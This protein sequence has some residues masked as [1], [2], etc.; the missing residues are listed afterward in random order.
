MRN[1]DV[2]LARLSSAERAMWDTISWV[3]KLPDEE[4][5]PMERADSFSFT[6]QSPAPASPERDSAGA[7]APLFAT[8]D[9]GSVQAA[10]L[11]CELKEMPAVLNFAHGF[12]CG[13]GFDHAPGSQEEDIFRKTSLFLSLWPH[14]R[15]DDGPGVLKRGKW[16]G[17]FDRYLP[18]KDAFYPHTECGG[19]YSP[20]VRVIRDQSGGLCDAQAVAKLPLFAVLTVAAQNVN[21]EP[22]FKPALLREKVRTVLWMAKVMGHD[23]VVLGAFGCGYFSN[24]PNVVAQTFQELL[25]SGGEFAHAFRTVVFAVPGATSRNFKIFATYFPTMSTRDFVGAAQSAA[26]RKCH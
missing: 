2:D 11:L 18:R 22:P 19:I 13:G 10:A 1:E 26:D 15:S 17:H 21:F 4:H 8:L 20:H 16:I 23:S 25:G 9:M 3:L 14:R 5:K 7:S 6:M 12:N 24:P